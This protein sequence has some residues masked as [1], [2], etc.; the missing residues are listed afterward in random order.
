MLAAALTVRSAAVRRAARRRRTAGLT[1]V[2][3]II[4]ITIIGSL[5]GVIAFAI[6]SSKEKAD[7]KIAALACKQFRTSVLTY[8]ASHPES[9]CVTPDQLKTEKEIDSTTNLK[10]PWNMPY[11][12]TCEGE[13]IRVCSTGPDKKPG[14]DD[15]CEPASSDKK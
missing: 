15:I 13:D 8:K 3:L 9:D 14:G 11:V 4:V 6:F 7:K 10:D 5:M 2:E 12:I 1:L